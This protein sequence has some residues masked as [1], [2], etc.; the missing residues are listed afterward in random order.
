[1]SVNATTDQD[2][3]PAVQ[4]CTKV[5]AQACRPDAFCCD[6]E[7]AK[8]E[9]IVNAACR[10]ALRQIRVNGKGIATSW[11]RYNSDGSWEAAKFTSLDTLLPDAVGAELCLVVWPNTACST[12]A[13]FCRLGKCQASIFSE[14]NKC[15]PTWQL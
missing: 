5:S 11:A 15:C 1:M 6:M 14:N 12:P 10:G 3:K 7:F 9:V 2:G 4:F 13:T 8:V